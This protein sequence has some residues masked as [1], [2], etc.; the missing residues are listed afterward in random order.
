MCNT[1][2]LFWIYVKKRPS[3]IL[4]TLICIINCTIYSVTIYFKAGWSYK[5]IIYNAVEY[6]ASIYV[7]EKNQYCYTSYTT[8]ELLLSTSSVGV[9]SLFRSVV[10]FS[11]LTWEQRGLSGANLTSAVLRDTLNLSLI[12]LELWFSA[13]YLHGLS[14]PR[15]SVQSRDYECVRML[16]ANTC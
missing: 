6:V 8:G 16:F 10:L 1:N 3:T 14:L 15:W 12:S 5:P 4:L 7:S 11:T 13:A 2:S 9:N